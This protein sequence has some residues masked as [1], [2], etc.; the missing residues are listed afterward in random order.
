MSDDVIY[1]NG[2]EIDLSDGRYVFHVELDGF[3]YFCFR[4]RITSNKPDECLEDE[5][6]QLL[7]SPSETEISHWFLRCPSGDVHD[8]VTWEKL[9]NVKDLGKE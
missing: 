9:C 8:A 4:N 6:I 3:H 5:L 2:H 7:V 1:L